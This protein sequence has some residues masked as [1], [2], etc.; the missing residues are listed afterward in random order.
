MARQRFVPQQPDDHAEEAKRLAWV[1]QDSIN[2]DGDEIEPETLSM[3]V[4]LGILHA[5][6]ALIDRV[7]K[8]E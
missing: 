2:N 8:A 6:V 3:L 4:Q 1:V 7:D 5:L